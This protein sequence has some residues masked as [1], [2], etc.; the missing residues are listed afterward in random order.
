MLI[1]SQLKKKRKY[2]SLDFNSEM[3]NELLINLKKRVIKMNTKFTEIEITNLI[4]ITTKKLY[5][6]RVHILHLNTFSE[7]IHGDSRHRQ[8][9]IS[10]QTAYS[11]IRQ[12]DL[13]HTKIKKPMSA[14]S[15]LE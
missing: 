6:R 4:K 15:H 5:G 7:V 12:T 14:L 1:I 9:I 13:E 3:E 8:N 10:I 11:S 2:V